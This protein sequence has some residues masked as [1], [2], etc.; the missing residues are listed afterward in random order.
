MK[1]Q[2]FFPRNIPNQDIALISTMG[3]NQPVG[4]YSHYP[5]WTEQRRGKDWS[6]RHICRHRTFSLVASE[7]YRAAAGATLYTQWENHIKVNF[8]LRGRHTTI[9][10]GFG[11]EEHERPEVFITCSPPETLKVDVL[12]AGAPAAGV[13]LCVL[14]E[15]FPEQMGLALEDLPEPIRSLALTEARP[16]F[17]HRFELTP[18]LLIAA[19]S[20]LAAP[21]SLR[22][23]PAYSQAKAVEL[24]CLLM[25]RMAVDRGA[26]W[27][28][29]QGRGAHKSRLHE[30]REFLIRQY[31]EGI[32][33]DHV[34]REVGLNRT[35]LTSGFRQLFGMTVYDF[36]QKVRMERAYELLQEGG[37]TVAQVAEA[38]GYAHSCT[39]STAFHGYFGCSPRQARPGQR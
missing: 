28:G 13:A 24:M 14:P 1:K 22:N 16:Y 4:E 31:A 23:Q 6:R 20:I 25:E 32:T 26:S 2:T 36:L 15:F 11:Q 5:A 17:L 30:A 12:G 18:E 9:L 7:S 35:A 29:T 21:C 39:F 38:V 10:D 33:L 3:L 37:R 8:R 27:P 34:C 19:R